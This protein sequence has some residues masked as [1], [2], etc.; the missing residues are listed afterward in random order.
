MTTQHKALPSGLEA[1]QQ[2]RYAEAINLLEMF[3]Q[4]SKVNRE[5]CQAHLSF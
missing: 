1:L 3:C 5:Y 2:G 4:L